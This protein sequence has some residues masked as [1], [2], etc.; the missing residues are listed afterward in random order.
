MKNNFVGDIGKC[1]IVEND[2]ALNGSF[3]STVNPKPFFSVV[4]MDF[5]KS[6][7]AVINFAFLLL[8][9]KLAKALGEGGI[10]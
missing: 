2:L 1:N 9:N 10:M 8:A 3:F 6:N 5:L 4:G 7:G